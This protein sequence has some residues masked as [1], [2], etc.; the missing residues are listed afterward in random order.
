MDTAAGA[1]GALAAGAAVAA[2]RS[3][4]FLIKLN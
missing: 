4:F 1:T 3:C 2:N